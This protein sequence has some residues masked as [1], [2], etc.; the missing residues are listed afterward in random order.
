MNAKFTVNGKQIETE[1]LIFRP[2]KETD[3]KDFYEYASVAGVGEMA[4][5]KHHESKEE[6]KAILDSFISNDHDFAI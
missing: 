5:W 6:S 1:R 3:L 4:G 2:F